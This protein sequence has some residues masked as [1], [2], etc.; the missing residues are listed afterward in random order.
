MP[1]RKQL[2]GRSDGQ[3]TDGRSDREVS[4][5]N[6]ELSVQGMPMDDRLVF[7]SLVRR[8]SLLAAVAEPPG[9]VPRAV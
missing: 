6:L 3:A 2:D 4:G 5:P 8:S 7:V 9:T 1:G